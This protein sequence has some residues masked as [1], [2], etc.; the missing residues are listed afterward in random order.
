MDWW[1]GFVN[2][3]M[4]EREE[5]S[6]IIHELFE[7]VR[8]DNIGTLAVCPLNKKVGSFPATVMARLMINYINEWVTK[9]IKDPT[10]KLNVIKVVCSSHSYVGQTSPKARAYCT[11]LQYMDENFSIGNITMKRLRRMSEDLGEPV[12]KLDVLQSMPLV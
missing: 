4:A 7:L 6:K 8:K 2:K 9:Y 12:D 5:F 1:L 3:G 11:E 10:F